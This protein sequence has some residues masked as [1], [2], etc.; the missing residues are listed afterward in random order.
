MLDF[1]VSHQDQCF[2]ICNLAIIKNQQIIQNTPIIRGNYPKCATYRGL[3]TNFEYIKKIWLV[4]KP[5]NHTKYS[6]N[7]R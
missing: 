1:D 6:Y 3:S 5:I 4:G 2:I 7:P